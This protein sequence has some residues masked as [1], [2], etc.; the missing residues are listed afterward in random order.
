MVTAPGT[1]PGEVGDYDPALIDS[2]NDHDTFKSTSRS[3]G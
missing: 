3:H 2:S 1:R